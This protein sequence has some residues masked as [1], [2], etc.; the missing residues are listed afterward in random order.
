MDAPLIVI[1]GVW[2]GLLA[3]ERRAF[4]QAMFSRPLV[5]A[6]GT[7]L[8]LGDVPSGLFT[9]LVLELFFLGGASLG[10]RH[11]DHELLPAVAASALAASCAGHGQGPSTPAMWGAALL[12]AMPLGPFGKWLENRIDA[13]A[14][15]YQGRAMHFTDTGAFHLV[16][17]QNL[18]AMWPTLIAYGAL[19]ALFA[20]LG[21]LLDS[22]LL[23]LP[24]D[25]LRGLAWTYPAMAAVA[26]AIAVHFS[27]AKKA[28]RKG[29]LAGLLVTSGAV[30][31][32]VWGVPR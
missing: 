1:T 6:I 25:A 14:I 29:L 27:H 18:R 9:G 23:R 11:P 30:A 31:Y 19:S 12:V 16:G 32:S 3:L 13:R 2:G 26:A 7:G 21:P 8:L 10:G 17:R 20:A 15:R 4:L 22:A 28:G 5:A 24:T